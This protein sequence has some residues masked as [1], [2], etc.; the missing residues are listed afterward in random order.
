[1]AGMNKKQ[2]GNVSGTCCAN[3]T[4][5]LGSFLSA[6]VKYLWDFSTNFIFCQWKFRSQITLRSK[7]P[8]FDLPSML[9]PQTA[10]YKSHS[11][12]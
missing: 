5:L 11:N 8:Y 4:G 9:V 10:H 3:H 12:L 6:K 7:T 1:M 2:K